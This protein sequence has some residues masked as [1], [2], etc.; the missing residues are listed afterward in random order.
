[1]GLF[2]WLERK[3]FLGDVV[4][5][6]GVLGENRVGIGRVRTSVFLC[7]R[8]GQPK[9]VFR[10]SGVSPLSANV[11]YMAV[12]VT[13]EVLEK[14]VDVARDAKALL[15]GQRLPETDPRRIQ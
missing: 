6:Y 15:E 10:H 9:L 12:D 11:S 4:K 1:M 14:L 8:W 7:R 2:G 3:L 5:N 13:P